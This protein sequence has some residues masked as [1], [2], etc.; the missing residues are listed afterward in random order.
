MSAI[1]PR[2]GPPDTGLRHM[3]ARDIFNALAITTANKFRDRLAFSRKN[4]KKCRSHLSTFGRVQD[5]DSSHELSLYR[6][7]EC[8]LG[9]P[10]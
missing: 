2:A 1:Q 4:E 5:G 3:V 8:Y 10:P 9:A 7:I 6:G